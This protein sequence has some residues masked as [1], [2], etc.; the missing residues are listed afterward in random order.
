[1]RYGRRTEIV[2]YMLQPPIIASAFC[3]ASSGTISKSVSSF[4]FLTVRN[5]PVTPAWLIS[6]CGGSLSCC[7]MLIL[8]FFIS[9]LKH[10]IGIN[11]TF[12]LSSVGSDCRWH[13]RF[14]DTGRQ[15][16]D[17][18]TASQCLAILIHPI[19]TGTPRQGLGFSQGY[20]DPEVRVGFDLHISSPFT[21]G[22][23]TPCQS[24]WDQSRAGIAVAIV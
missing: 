23:F 9:T 14:S 7:C 4:W 10:Q 6:V 1:M 5:L 13:H 24:R 15:G 21:T 12:V 2:C 17:R 20:P 16:T 8:T 3:F 22:L 11:I 18:S 19:Q